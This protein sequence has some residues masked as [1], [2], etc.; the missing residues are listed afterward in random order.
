MKKIL[1]LISFIL[2]FS[3]SFVKANDTPALDKGLII[4]VNHLLADNKRQETQLINQNTRL[5]QLEH[6]TPIGHYCILANACPANTI[7]KGIVGYI[8]PKNETCGV[9]TSGGGDGY[10][11]DWQWCHPRLCCTK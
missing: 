11:S 9:G 3:V 4:L 10:S 6:K 5:Q 7:D 8:Q 2:I 1:T